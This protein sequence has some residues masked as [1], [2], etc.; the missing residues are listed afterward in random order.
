VAADEAACA[1]DQDV[2]SVPSVFHQD[3]CSAS[4]A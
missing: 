2:S 3:N 1:G 4:R